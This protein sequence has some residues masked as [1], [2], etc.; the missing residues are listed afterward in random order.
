MIRLCALLTAVLWL[1]AATVLAD[2]RGVSH[3]LLCSELNAGQVF[4]ASAGHRLQATLQWHGRQAIQRSAGHFLID[5]CS[6]HHF[7]PERFRRLFEDRFDASPT[8]I[9]GPQERNG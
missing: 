1:N 6:G 5:G 8:R 3:Q 2:T 9:E 4:A 7:D